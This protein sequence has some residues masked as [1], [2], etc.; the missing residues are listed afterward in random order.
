MP[1]PKRRTKRP[2]A[3]DIAQEITA[4]LIARL[5]EGGPLP[6]RRPWQSSASAMPLR[7]T[8]D[9]Y[10]GVNHFLLAIETACSGYT[11][12]FWMTFRQAK[13]LGGS[14]RKGERSSTVVYYG[15]APKK[16]EPAEQSDGEEG[17]TY[18]FLKGYAVF[19]SDQI[20]DLPERFHPVAGEIDTGVR[21][22]ELLYGFFDR[23]PFDIDH[24][25]EYAAYQEMQDR[26][27]MP[28]PSRFESEGAYFSTLG[29]EAIHSS[30]IRN[31]LA[32]ECFAN[33]HADKEARAAEE[34]I[35]EIGC[36]MVNA[37][38]GIAGEHIDNHAAYVA[39]W[40]AAL[41]SD[42]R[43]IFKAAAAAQIACDWLISKGGSVAR[44]EDDNA[45][46]AA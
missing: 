24:G 30:G 42:K 29:H 27:V 22:N 4:K 23:M 38:L 45:Q 1:N 33:Y 28:D 6:W 16:D 32:R 9:A 40:L 44:A 20:D 13:E 7:V 14:V 35:A 43:H 19:N 34:L 37:H 41:K 18:R 11:S 15:Q 26:I 36:L 25:F 10:K 3:R 21:A 17:S 31:R 39:S 8:G 5:E 12:P 46:V 2:P